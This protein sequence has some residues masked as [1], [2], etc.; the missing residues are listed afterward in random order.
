VLILGSTGMLGQ[1]LTNTAKLNNIKVTGVARSNADVNIDIMDFN[2]LAL[3]LR[4][5]APKVI[6]NCIAITDINLCESDV[7]LAYQVNANFVALL[8][9]ICR[10]LDIRLI[11]IST[12]HFFVND[13][14]NKHNE[15]AEVVLVNNYAKSKYAG[16]RFSLSYPNSLV[17]RTNI[18][19]FRN[20]Q[21]P[22]FVEWVL[23]SLKSQKEITL[24]Q[25]FY[26]SGI[27]VYNLSE[28]L[29]KILDKK[30]SPLNGLINIACSE[31]YNKEKFIKKFAS[32]FGYNDVKFITGSI[33]SMSGTKRAESLGLDIQKVELILS[34]KMPTLD[35]VIESLYINK[36]N[37]V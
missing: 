8:V 29:L 26:T 28:I 12:D 9:D 23:S 15:I 31:V 25:D 19:G 6:I 3:F 1:A 7:G 16:E 4:K 17:V 36:G 18:V 11:H 37:N 33:L 22:T 13:N 21:N 10:E 27:D 2:K 34:M 24:F 5:K 32:V 30:S 20:S 35:E 14:S